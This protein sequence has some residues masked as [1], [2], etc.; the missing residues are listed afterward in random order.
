MIARTWRGVTA[1]AR[2]DAYADYLRETGLAAYRATPGNIA[3]LLLRRALDGDRTEFVTFTLW[4]SMTSIRQFAGD[5]PERAVF[6]PEDDDYLLERDLAVTHHEVADIDMANLG[7][8]DGP[9]QPL[10]G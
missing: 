6:Y 8:T 5:E 3:A 2:A 9:D 4:E 1:T 7:R 10:V